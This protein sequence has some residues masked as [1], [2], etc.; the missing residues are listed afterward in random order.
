MSSPGAAPVDDTA[1]GRLLIYGA[2][3][4]VGRAAAEEARARGWQPIVAGRDGQAVG[5]VARELALEP[6]V[7]ALEDPSEVREGLAGVAVAVNMAGPFALTWRPLVEACLKSGT[8]YVDITG[9]MDVLIDMAQFDAAAKNR[10]VMLLPAAGLDS[11]PADCLAAYLCARLPSATRVRLGIRT[12]GPAWLPPGTLKTMIRS[13]HLPDKVIRSGQP[14]EVGGT[15]TGTID[16]GDGP[17]T[18]VRY[19][20]ADTLVVN[21]TTGVGDVEAYVALPPVAL[22]GYLGLRT[23]RRLLSPRSVRELMARFVRGGSTAEQRRRS[24]TVVWAEA[25]DDAG[26]RVTARLHGPEGAVVWTVRTALDVAERGLTGRAVPGLQ[27]AGAAF[28]PDFVLAAPGVT[29]VDA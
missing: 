23:L 27:T 5:R 8:H 17:V 6:R 7:F 11:V 19:Q 29:R 24:R 3:G 28:G 25:R 10:G 12:S 4:F 22:A 21:R 20:A 16:F 18:A 2:N 26:G 13:A 1:T 9:E 14:V 15:A